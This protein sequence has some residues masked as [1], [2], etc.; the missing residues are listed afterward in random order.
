[1]VPLELKARKTFLRVGCRCSPSGI[2]PEGCITSKHL[3][4][5]CQQRVI[6]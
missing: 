6:F 3:T 1:V 4:A 2:T 5:Y